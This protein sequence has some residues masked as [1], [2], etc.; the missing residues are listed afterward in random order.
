MLEFSPDKRATAEQMLS[1]AWLLAPDCED[2]SAAALP[3]APPT[4]AESGDVLGEEDEDDEGSSSSSGC[5]E[6]V[7]GEEQ[8]HVQEEISPPRPAN[9]DPLPSRY[10]GLGFRSGPV[11]LHGSSSLFMADQVPP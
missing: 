7:T 5:W 1:H 10:T 11:L 3:L 6:E 8:E 9:V 2:A 4:G